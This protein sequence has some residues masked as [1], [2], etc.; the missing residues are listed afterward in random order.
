[1]VNSHEQK[2]KIGNVIRA[3]IREY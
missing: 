3:L 2:R 1:M